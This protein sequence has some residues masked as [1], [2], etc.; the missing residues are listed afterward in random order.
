MIKKKGKDTENRTKE[1]VKGN[2]SS[3]YSR[4]LVRDRTTE[5]IQTRPR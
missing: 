3:I 5:R 1:R 4:E 2:R